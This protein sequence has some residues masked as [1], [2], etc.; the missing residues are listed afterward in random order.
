M[1]DETEGEK[2]G[3]VRFSPNSQFWNYLGWLSRNT[4]LGKTENEVARQ[5][6]TD[7]L[8]EMRQED[9]RDDKRS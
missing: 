8:T 2:P 6:L 4:L 3:E 7:K 5:V 9:Y 1:A